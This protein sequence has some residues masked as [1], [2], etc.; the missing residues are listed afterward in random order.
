MRK[1]TLPAIIMVVLM[2]CICGC[3]DESGQKVE[4]SSDQSSVQSPVQSSVQSYVVTDEEETKSSADEG[5]WQEAYKSIV[6]MWQTNHGADYAFGYN[7]IYLDDNDFP[8]LLLMGED[9]AW[10]GYE[11][12][13]FIDGEAVRVTKDDSDSSS[14]LSP[15]RQMQID[16]FIPRTGIWVQGSGMMGSIHLTGYRLEGAK[17]QIIGNADGEDEEMPKID[18]IPSEQLEVM[19]CNMNYEDIYKCLN[20]NASL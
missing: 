5:G 4:Q 15:G 10:N 16:E 14:Y 13:T 12:Y 20:G 19:E 2:V 8:E 7:L 17:L 1:N 9:D 6:D 11:M 3:G 18:G